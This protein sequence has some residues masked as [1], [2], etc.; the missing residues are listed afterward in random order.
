[1]LSFLFFIFIDLVF[2]VSPD[3]LLIVVLV[4]A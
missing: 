3:D 2:V 1:M 4:L